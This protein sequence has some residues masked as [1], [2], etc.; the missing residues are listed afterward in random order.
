MSLAL[1]LSRYAVG[2]CRRDLELRRSTC[3]EGNGIVLEWMIGEGC[4]R[5]RASLSHVLQRL[6]EVE[7]LPG[8]RRGGLSMRSYFSAR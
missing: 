7:D 2:N 6:K 5:G 4:S 3:F 1:V 8:L